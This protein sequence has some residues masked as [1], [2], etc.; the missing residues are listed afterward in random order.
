M[1]SYYYYSDGPK[2]DMEK[3]EKNENNNED[4]AKLNAMCKNGNQEQQEEINLEKAFKSL[5]VQRV[6]LGFNSATE[7]YK[8]HKDEFRKR[9][10]RERDASH[11]SLFFDFEEGCSYYVDYLPIKG[12]SKTAKFVY[13]D[14]Y[15]LRYAEKNFKDLNAFSRFIS[16]CC[17]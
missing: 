2:T 1:G 5:K 6:Y 11:P 17:S 7:I 4:F 3:I 16:S 8:R 12:E 13:R 14:D 9:G 15:G 10:L